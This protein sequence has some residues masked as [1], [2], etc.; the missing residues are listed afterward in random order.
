MRQKAP[1]RWRREIAAVARCFNQT[2]R[3][4]RRGSSAA[5][6]KGKY[7]I[8]V[9]T[10][11]DRWVTV[12]FSRYYCRGQLA[13][14]MKIFL[15]NFE[16]HWT[17]TADELLRSNVRKSSL[18]MFLHQK[19]SSFYLSCGCSFVWYALWALVWWFRW[20]RVWT[21]FAANLYQPAGGLV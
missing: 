15:E 2:R 19:I 10:R 8:S 6:A 1:G 18:I 12:I 17:K 4:W 20:S 9:V 14:G 7:S 16:C 11:V 5:R 3:W 13:S 21:L